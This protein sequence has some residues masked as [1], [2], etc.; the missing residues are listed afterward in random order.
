VAHRGSNFNTR[1]T[2][3]DFV[4]APW[5]ATASQTEDRLVAA[6]RQ[7]ARLALLSEGLDVPEN[8]IAVV[9]R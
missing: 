9:V 3:E 5:E 7:A 4:A 1:V 8:R 6:V 2:L